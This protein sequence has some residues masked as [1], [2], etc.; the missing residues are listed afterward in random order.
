VNIAPDGSSTAEVGHARWVRIHWHDRSETASEAAHRLVRWTRAV[1]SLAGL[2]SLSAAIEADR[3]KICGSPIRLVQPE[4]L[5]RILRARDAGRAA[6]HGEERDPL[7]FGLDLHDP[8]LKAADRVSIHSQC[9]GSVDFIGN[10]ITVALPRSCRFQRATGWHLSVLRSLIEA[11]DP[12]EAVDQA[13]LRHLHPHGSALEA[14]PI[15][16]RNF[17]RWDSGRRPLQPPIDVPIPP[18]LSRPWLGGTLYE[19]PEHAAL[20]GA[21][22]D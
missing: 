12:D 6:L 14:E 22:P 2:C 18:P 16:A 17:L 9:G 4:Q 10:T 11:F 8:A 1:G 15:V 7:G 19:W 21:T 13:W 20:V 5:I 3:A